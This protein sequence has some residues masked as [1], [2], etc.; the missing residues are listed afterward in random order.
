MAILEK[1]KPGVMSNSK[2]SFTLEIKF[3]PTETKWNTANV[4][5]Y[6]SSDMTLAYELQN[7]SVSE[8]GIIAITDQEANGIAQN[9]IY[10]VEVSNNNIS[11]NKRGII[12]VVKPTITGLNNINYETH[13]F[14]FTYSGVNDPL[15]RYRVSITPPTASGEQSEISD[16][17]LA[18]T[19][20]SN[21][22]YKYELS[23]KASLT[24]E[25]KI[26]FESKYGY[27]SELKT[28]E[29]TGLSVQLYRIPQNYDTN[30]QL[31]P[32]KPKVK[33]NEEYGCIELSMPQE[34]VKYATSITTDGTNY[35]LTIP[36]CYGCDAN[37]DRRV[38]ST[39]DLNLSRSITLTSSSN[40]NVSSSSSWTIYVPID[41]ID[42]PNMACV[43]FKIAG[44]YRL[45]KEIGEGNF[46]EF[47]H[48]TYITYSD[49][50][51]G[52]V[53]KDYDVIQGQKYNYY[54]IPT[55]FDASV[56]APAAEAR[57]NWDA[58]LL[59]D[60]SG[61]Q[62]TVQYNPQISSFKT[63]IGEQKQDTLGGKYPFFLRN[64]DMGYKE[65]PIS[66]LISYKADPE[67]KMQ[68]AGMPAP[69]TSTRGSTASQ[70]I[71]ELGEHDEF[72]L[73]RVYKRAVEDWL[74]NGEP[75][76]LRTA[77]EGSFIVRLTN[78]SLSP[79]QQLGR[80]LHTFSATAYEI[81]D[82]T[83]AKLNEYGLDCLNS[84]PNEA[85]TGSAGTA[86]T[87]TVEEKTIEI[88]NI[89]AGFGDDVFAYNYSER[90]PACPTKVEFVRGSSDVIFIT[91][92][93]GADNNTIDLT[94]VG[95]SR[96]IE[97]QD[98]SH[99]R[100]YVLRSNPE[101]T[102][103]DAK[104]KLTYPALRFTPTTGSEGET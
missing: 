25:V 59:S 58:I 79:M 15:F 93:R 34:I 82:Y 7:V 90:L 67:N 84:I 20:T 3:D 52:Y 43:G 44:T 18:P 80:L 9:Q 97:G 12:F 96:L 76:L 24:Y 29:E 48:L 70:Q 10:L 35:T 75:K 102:T 49:D 22:Q 78:V 53:Y 11:L 30:P 4:K 57:A 40:G 73:E 71:A 13:S 36:Y 14:N 100:C 92:L 74:N 19:D 39:S 64:G 86:G 94:E 85:P 104:V 50:L 87:I 2:I 17:I 47:K 37:G 99:L 8:K 6:Q 98:L 83:A 62:L 33:V 38:Y 31:I 61:R 5:F 26:E 65:I 60:A 21:L 27:L 41:Q 55:E 32:I 101:T 56:G 68:V 63:T 16:W 28:V 23:L 88:T 42:L 95:T 51:I 1:T 103:S 45:V 66:G 54:L 77:A 46:K 69:V 91:N 81:A 72:Y 89:P